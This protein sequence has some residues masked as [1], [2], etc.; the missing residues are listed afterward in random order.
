MAEPT[1]HEFRKICEAQIKMETAYCYLCGKPIT[2]LKDLTVD[3]EPPRSR[4]K[5]LGKSNLYPCCAKCNHQKG[6]LTLEEYKQWLVL[7]R[8]RNGNQ[9]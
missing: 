6:A 2:K 9:K 1:K 4:Q 3:H 8:K 7:E 5:E